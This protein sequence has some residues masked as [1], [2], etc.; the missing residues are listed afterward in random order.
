MS[1]LGDNGMLLAYYGDDFTGSTDVMEALTT[2]GVEAALFLE[3]PDERA[4]ARFAGYRALGLAGVSRSQ[5]P[6]WMDEHLPPA[7]EWLRAAGAPLCHYK[8]C[9]T[10]DSA[11]HAGSIGRAIDIGL[12]MFDAP[13]APVVA[14]APSFGRYT[15]FANLLPPRARKFTASTAIRR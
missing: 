14:G 5:S 7:F 15:L 8:V 1:G 9:S 12:R 6:A 11:P 3:T 13:F 4:L 2:N 10:F